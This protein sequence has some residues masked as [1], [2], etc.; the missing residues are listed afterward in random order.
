MASIQM[1]S[2]LSLST[3][4]KLR[5]LSICKAEAR[6][7]FTVNGSPLQRTV[8]LLV[9][10]ERSARGE[11]GSPQVYDRALYAGAWSS[12]PIHILNDRGLAWSGGSSL[13]SRI[14]V[15]DGSE[16]CWKEEKD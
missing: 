8:S 14:H 1:Y 16:T 15:D 6:F 2:C 5:E 11:A 12:S 7:G 4:S 9:A 10:R 13:M 3:A